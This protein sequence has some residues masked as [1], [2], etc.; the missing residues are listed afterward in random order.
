MEPILRDTV[1]NEV[2]SICFRW[3]GL[4]VIRV[5]TS[6]SIYCRIQNPQFK[7]TGTI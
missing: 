1:R 5:I 3:L 4:Y 2:K 7:T 6:F